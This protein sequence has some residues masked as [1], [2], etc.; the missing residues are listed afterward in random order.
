VSEHSAESDALPCR[1]GYVEY[2]G[3]QYCFEHGGFRNHYGQSWS[4]D[5]A[6]VSPPGES[7][8]QDGAP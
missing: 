1:L 6:R 5:R 4:C 7:A 8:P 2:D 3:Y